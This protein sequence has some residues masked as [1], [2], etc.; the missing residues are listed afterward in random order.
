[1]ALRAVERCARKVAGEYRMSSGAYS[2]VAAS[3]ERGDVIGPVSVAV[4]MVKSDIEDVGCRAVLW[5]L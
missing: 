2:D 5:S 4:R 1:M 3:R